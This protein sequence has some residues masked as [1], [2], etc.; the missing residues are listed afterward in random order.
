M[1]AKHNNVRVQDVTKEVLEASDL[2]MEGWACFGIDCK[3]RG[4]MGNAMYRQIKKDPKA[5]DTYKWLFE[6]KR[7]SV[8]HGRFIAP[9]IS[10]LRRGSIRSV[11][12]RSRRR[13]DPTRVSYS[14]KFTLVAQDTLKLFV[15]PRITLPIA[16]SSRPGLWHIQI[17]FSIDC[18]NLGLFSCFVWKLLLNHFCFEIPYQT[19]SLRY[20]KRLD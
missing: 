8:K 12:R 2:G 13:L 20:G 16:E 14:W 18:F 5:N 4:P 15:K 10:F 9:S 1:Y 17:K 7:S 11:R 3:A 6:D 19:G